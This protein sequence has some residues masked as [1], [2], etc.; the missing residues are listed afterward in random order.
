MT[1]FFCVLVFV[2]HK[3][4]PYIISFMLSCFCLYDLINLTLLSWFYVMALW[5][6][7]P[8]L[9]V[10]Y[11]IVHYLSPS[12]PFYSPHLVFNPFYLQCVDIPI[13]SD[14]DCDNSY[15]GQITDRM[16]CAGYLEGGKDSCQVYKHN[17]TYHT[18][19]WWNITCCGN[20]AV[21]TWHFKWRLIVTAIIAINDLIVFLLLTVIFLFES[22]ALKLH[23][24]YDT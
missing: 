1:C 11:N 5:V 2:F 19:H 4:S 17:I 13:L 6:T 15:P 22:W 24:R 12:P 20:R 21:V 9:R 10:E 3:T 23:S 18:V 8:A 16:V 7:D 14:K